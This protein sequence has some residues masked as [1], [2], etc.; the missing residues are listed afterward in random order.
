MKRRQEIKGNELRLQEKELEHLEEREE[1]LGELSVAEEIKKI[2]QESELN[3][4]MVLQ[5][6]TE[7]SVKQTK[8]HR[9][10]DL[11]LV[12]QRQADKTAR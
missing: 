1:L 7:N 5:G 6:V 9:I 4:T 10:S 8:N 2:L 11:K 3:D 12:G